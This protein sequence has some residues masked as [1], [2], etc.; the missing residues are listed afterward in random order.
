[1]DFKINKPTNI[2]ALVMIIIT[3]LIFI[4]LP[5]FSYLGFFNTNQANDINN[6]TNTF[7]II[8]EILILL[9][10]LIIIIGLF[11]IVPFIWY[12]LV[13]KY[14]YKEILN[15]LKLK[16]K[17]I[18]IAFL[19]GIIIAITSLILII[20]IGAILLYFGYDL[21]DASNIPELEQYFTLPTIIFLIIFQPLAEEIFFR[22]FLLEKID[23]LIGEK[24]AI[25]ITSLLFGIA[26]L[27]FGNVYPAITTG[28]IGILLAFIVIKTQNLYSAITAHIFFNIASFSM[29]IFAQSIL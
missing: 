18:D 6:Y 3:F 2:F 25:I 24:S 4:T 27:S 11:I 8:Y 9:F 23:S 1:M 13:N 7:G 21:S 5:L 10:Q 22:G 26:H 19:W 15:K 28:I 20:T 29:Y 17:G 12:N 14:S 16:K